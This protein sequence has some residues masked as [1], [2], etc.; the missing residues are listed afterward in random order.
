MN[1]EHPRPL[2]LEALRGRPRSLQVLEES[3]RHA[4]Q[5][6]EADRVRAMLLGMGETRT[7]PA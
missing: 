4:G 7:A 6:A 1:P 3:Y 5:T 2:D